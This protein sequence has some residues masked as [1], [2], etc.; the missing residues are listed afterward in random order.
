MQLTTFS[1]IAILF[2]ILY[3]LNKTKKAKMVTK[4]LQKRLLYSPIFRSQIQF[5]YPTCLES[6][7]ILSQCHTRNNNIKQCQNL[8]VLGWIQA[9]SKLL[10]AL[11]IPIFSFIHLK[12]NFKKLESITFRQKYNTL[13][14]NLYPI[15]SSVYR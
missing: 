12:L 15:K 13:Y 10:I 3:L 7:I 11:F 1:V 5:F 6:F 4:E 8:S 2:A 14:N 9:I